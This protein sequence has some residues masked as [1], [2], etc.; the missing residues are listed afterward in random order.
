MVHPTTQLQR[1][2]HYQCTSG[3]ACTHMHTHT[4]LAG[5]AEVKAA[6]SLRHLAGTAESGVNSKPAC[7]LTQA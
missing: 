5:Q 1:D 2:M 6:R 3:R 4:Q 7:S